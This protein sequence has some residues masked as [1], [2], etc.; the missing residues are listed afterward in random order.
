V[1]DFLKQEKKRSKIIV[2]LAY[3]GGKANPEVKFLDYFALVLLSYKFNSS[4]NFLILSDLEKPKALPENVR[5]EHFTAQDFNKLAAKKLG[6]SIDIS[7]WPYKICDYRP[8]FGLIFSD[9]FRGFDFWG[10]TDPDVIFGDIRAFVTEKMLSKQN[11]VGDHG[12]LTLFRNV[13]KINNI[14][15]LIPFDSKKLAEHYHRLANSQNKKPDIFNPAVYLGLEEDSS[16][17][18]PWIAKKHKLGIISLSGKILD[19]LAPAKKTI[20]QAIFNLLCG[21]SFVL[22]GKKVSNWKD[23]A[24]PW[25]GTPMSLSPPGASKINYREHPW[26]NGKK[27]LKFFWA[28]GKVFTEWQKGKKKLLKEWLYIHLQKR[29]MEIKLDVNDI[30]NGFWIMPD[31]FEKRT[32][33]APGP[34]EMPELLYNEEYYGFIK[35]S[36]SQSAKVVV[37]IVFNLLKPRSVVDVGCGTGAWLTVFKKYGAKEI[38]G[39]DGPWVNKNR[40][41]IPKKD[42]LPFD[43]EKKFNIGKKFG[44]VVSLEVAEHLPQESAEDFV[45][46]LTSL[47]PIVLFSAAIKFQDAGGHINNQ[48]PDYWKKL[49]AKKNYLPFDCIRGKIW[50]NKKVSYWYRQNIFLFVQKDFLNSHHSLKKMLEKSSLPGLLAVHPEKYMELHDQ[51]QQVTGSKSYRAINCLKKALIVPFLFLIGKKIICLAFKP[52]EKKKPAK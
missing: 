18:I 27:N 35:K 14:Y 22:R 31:K 47:G 38:L 12:H 15:S 50:E 23:F 7:A 19:I 10:Y 34:E 52:A 40:L 33:R 24:C 3:F 44:L 51:L 8:F 28:N 5:F 29:K 30:P 46:S 43:L 20:P 9:Y 36:S 26:A 41:L 2:F 39:I 49:F 25:L 4:V 48:W 45:D 37:P 11:I 6:V 1:S 32:T 21:L 17:G 13:P 16:F 42:F